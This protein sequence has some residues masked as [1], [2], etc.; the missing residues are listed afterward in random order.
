MRSVKVGLGFTLRTLVDIAHLGHA[1]VLDVYI[2]DPRSDR[3]DTK[4][5]TRSYGP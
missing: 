3:N 2:M 4:K 1:H 5:T